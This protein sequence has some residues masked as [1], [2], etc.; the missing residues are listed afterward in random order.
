M[1][2]NGHVF[3]NKIKHTVIGAP[4]VR[5]DRTRGEARWI[6]LLGETPATKNSC[7][8]FYTDTDRTG[9]YTEVLFDGAQVNLINNFP[10]ELFV[11]ILRAKGY[12][13]TKP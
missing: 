1:T 9:Y 5:V 2:T 3:P 13:V 4:V 6:D 12:M 10:D 8:E 11:E 7:F